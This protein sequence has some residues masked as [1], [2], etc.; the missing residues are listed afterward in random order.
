DEDIRTFLD[1]TLPRQ[2]VDDNRVAIVA[3][4][5]RAG[6]GLRRDAV[7]ALDEGDAAI[8]AFLKEGFV[9]AIVED[10]QVATAT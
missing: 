5:D 7:A 4:L 2:T 9:P 8:A 1:V 10:L 3:S 6:R